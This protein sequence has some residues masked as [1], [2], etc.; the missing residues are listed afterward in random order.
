MPALAGRAWRALADFLLPPQ[1]AGCGEVIEAPGALCASCWSRIDFI[2]EPF[3]DRLGIPF[4]FEAGE[5]ALSAQAVAAP[6]A[7]ARARAVARYDDMA[8]RLVHNLKYKDRLECAPLMG[9]WMLRAGAGLVAGSD[10]IAPVPLY[11]ARLWR[12]RFN[13]A[14]LL[15]GR[16]SALGE[17]RLSEDMLGR[18]RSTRSQ[19]GLNMAERQR[20]VAGAFAV[21]PK[22]RGA[23]K[24]AN[25]LLVDDVI[26]TGATIEACTKALL[27]AGAAE[28][29][30]LAF[31]RVVDP[32]RLPV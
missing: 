2:A 24:G 3:C 31:A 6:P 27:R 11:R 5:G 20:N 10:Y 26:T 9:E 17:V 21:A 22:W 7:Y 16:I 8:R 28:V 12:R 29:N 14:A 23:V 30:V 19:V 18:I 13:Q 32:V 15:A 4:P 25:V 1:C